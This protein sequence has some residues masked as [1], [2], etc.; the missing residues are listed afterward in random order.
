MDIVTCYITC[1]LSF[2]AQV[3]GTKEINRFMRGIYSYDVFIPKMAAIELAES[4]RRFCRAYLWEAATSCQEFLPHFPLFPKLHFLHEIGFRLKREATRGNF[5]LNPSVWAC[6]LDED[7]IGR[8][9]ALTRTVSPMLVPLRTL[10]RYLAHL[11]I[12]WSRG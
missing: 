9:A 7:F 10:E 5:C 8:A 3:L 1:L 6:A 12:L 4:L 11:Q 2:G